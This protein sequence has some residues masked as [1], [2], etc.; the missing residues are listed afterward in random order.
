MIRREIERRP[1]DDDR[2]VGDGRR[3]QLVPGEPPGRL[4][5]LGLQPQPVPS[6]RD[7]NPSINEDGKGHGWS[8]R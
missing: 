7:V 2:P 8:P 6:A 5:L 4:D 3:G 1:R